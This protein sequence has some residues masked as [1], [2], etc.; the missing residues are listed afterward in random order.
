L[1]DRRLGGIVISLFLDPDFWILREDAVSERPHPNKAGEDPVV[2]F[3]R[4]E[5]LQHWVLF[6]C[7]TGLAL[8]GLALFFQDTFLGRWLI[9][10]EG[11]I[12]SR[13]VLHRIFAVGLMALCAWH[14]VYILFTE[15]GHRQL[16]EM[17][18]R[19]ADFR[20]FAGTLAYY[21]FRRKEMPDFGRYT[22]IQ[23]LQY[24]GAAVG[25]LLMILTG[26][27]L[28]SETTSMAMTGKWV[29]DVTAVIHGYQGLILFMLLFGWHLYIVHLS[30][31]NFPMQR[32][33]LDGRISRRRLWEEHRG[34]YIETFGPEPPP[35][36]EPEQ[37]AAGEET[38]IPPDGGRS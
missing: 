18:P 30:Q 12:E 14:L 13:G 19:A 11:G 31:G 29:L 20:D 1:I 33:F 10:V 23:K 6:I 8:T 5:L 37:P 17:R 7:L 38:D 16:M 2:R 15:R 27:A 36:V 4:G 25:S 9:V 28:W 26:L 35:G 3:T 21:F 22:P 24:W 34:E 32:T